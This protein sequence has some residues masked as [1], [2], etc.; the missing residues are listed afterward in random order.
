MDFQL[1]VT[2]I[3]YHLDLIALRWP[4]LPETK[5]VSSLLENGPFGCSTVIFIPFL[6]KKLK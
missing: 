6:K 1:F 3:A 2:S 5:P 4:G